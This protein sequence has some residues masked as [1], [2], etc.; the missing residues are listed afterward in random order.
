[1]IR[2]WLPSNPDDRQRYENAKRAAVAGGGH[3]MDYNARKQDTIRE[4]DDRLFRTAPCADRRW[5]ERRPLPGGR[6]P[7][8]VRMRG[9]RR[10]LPAA[11]ADYLLHEA[12]SVITEL[13]RTERG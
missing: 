1:M 5:L 7:Q 2:D 8:P 4:I 10:V 13:L 9:G 3:V 6:G 12:H 11:A